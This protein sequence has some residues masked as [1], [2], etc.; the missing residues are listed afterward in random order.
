MG[1][2]PVHSIGIALFE[3]VS[4]VHWFR[5]IG[6]KHYPYFNCP[7]F[8]KCKGCRPGLFT[9][10]PWLNQKDCRANWFKFIGID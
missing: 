10:L 9:L 6:Y 3:N 5:D 8:P 2:A 1:D 7:D 4:K